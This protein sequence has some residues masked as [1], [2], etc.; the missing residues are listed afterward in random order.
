MPKHTD[1]S[2]TWISIAEGKLIFHQ[3]VRLALVNMA[4]LALI[5]TALSIFV[6]TLEVRETNQSIDSH[7]FVQT[8]RLIGSDWSDAVRFTAGKEASAPDFLVGV[9]NP[10]TR[11]LFLSAPISPAMTTTLREWATLPGAPM[12][13]RSFAISGIPYRGLLTA[14]GDVQ[15]MVVDNVG[16]EQSVLNHLLTLFILAGCFGV[17]LTIV[18]GYLLGSWTLRPL[19][20]ARQREQEL[21][22]DVSHE[23][24]TPL[25]ALTTHVELLLRH[26]EEPISSHMQ[27]MEAIYGE[28][29]RMSRMVHELL[30]LSRLESGH[31]FLELAPVS[32]RELCEAAATIYEPVLEED[33]LAFRLDIEGDC[34]IQADAMRIRQLLI[35]L[36]DNARKY[37]SE[38]GVTL[39]ARCD[40]GAA[41]IRVADTGCGIAEDLLHRAT[42]RFARGR[43]PRRGE[44]ST[45]LGLAIA[46]RIVEAHRGKLTLHS[47]VGTG[48]EVIVRIRSLGDQP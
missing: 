19:M 23:L 47:S 33:G 9:W 42:E 12:Q 32:V 15:L 37:T 44:Y 40:S 2:R 29:R 20:A 10:K 46:K 36:L 31:D 25:S 14:H 18:G 1:R 5:W 22:T 17:L 11:R 26:A 45:G 13:F 24:R 4:V 43:S 8:E 27:W 7:L 48:T 30:D 38:G 35:I 21:M 3:R 28:V 16:D 39:T 6:Y 34:R 41:E